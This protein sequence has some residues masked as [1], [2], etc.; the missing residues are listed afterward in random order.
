[1]AGESNKFVTFMAMNCALGFFSRYYLS[2]FN[3]LKSYLEEYVFTDAS[4]GMISL[5]AAGP[6][7]GAAIISLFTGSLAKKYGRRK[8][9]MLSDVFSII[10][11]ALTMSSDFIGFLIGRIVTGFAL[12]IN[13]SLASVYI[14][15][16]APAKIRASLG[17][18]P[19]L[20]MSIGIT[21]AYALAFCVPNEIAEG[22]TN[23]NWRI[24]LAVPAV[25]FGIRLLLL[26]FVFKTDTPIASMSI[27][28][29]EEDAVACLKKIYKNE[30][31]AVA[32]FNRL[33]AAKKVT[34]SK[35][36]VTL[37]Q[38]FTSKQYRK[39]FFVGNLIAALQMLCGLT[40]IVLYSTAVFKEGLVDP[41]KSDS[42][43]VLTLLFGISMSV[44]SILST[45]TTKKLNRKPVLV[46]GYVIIGLF[47]FLFSVI[48]FATD[49]DR[50]AAKIMIII[51]G[52][53]FGM[54]V[55]PA[56]FIYLSELLPEIGYSFSIFT[57]WVFSYSVS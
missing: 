45:C 23:N 46:W 31:D 20:F 41:H 35:P 19:T 21:L 1:M 32:E 6:P 8:I 7:L 34:D 9:F 16:I 29:K 55:S 44:G 13:F 57:Y 26:I 28:K 17:S 56:T 54:T 25:V 11:V 48:S 50:L 39:A 27:H 51:W 30:A 12:G 14:I 42:P 37:K 15:E 18:Y 4:K 43:K 5:L 53:P 33:Q 38:L 40:P 22:T 24:L 47:A 3:S 10:G 36:V 52:F 2:I 49:G